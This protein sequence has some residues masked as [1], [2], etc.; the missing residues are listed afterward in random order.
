MR[1]TAQ[2]S[3]SACFVVLYQLIKFFITLRSETLMLFG[4]YPAIFLQQ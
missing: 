3:V 2:R 1:D 4:S